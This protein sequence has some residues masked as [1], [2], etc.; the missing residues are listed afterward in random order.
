MSSGFLRYGN[1]YVNAV[2]KLSLI[3]LYITGDVW[4]CEIMLISYVYFM[5]RKHMQFIIFIEPLRDN[6]WLQ[7][8]KYNII[9]TQMPDITMS[10]Q[11]MLFVYHPGCVLCTKCYVVSSWST[12]YAV[13]SG[14]DW[15]FGIS[16]VIR[17]RQ[18]SEEIR[19]GFN[20][21]TGTASS[22]SSH[23]FSIALVYWRII[24]IVCHHFDLHD[25]MS[26]VSYVTTC[27]IDQAL[28][29]M[30]KSH[31]VTW[32]WITLSH[33]IALQWVSSSASWIGSSTARRGHRRV[34]NQRRW[35][36]WPWIQR[37]D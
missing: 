23:R 3:L 24:E 21:S 17:R 33:F 26:L 34:W 11:I 16:S 6:C 18:S 2:C 13:S 22:G 25:F 20:D 36:Y 7:Q 1:W 5:Q 9:A 8:L 37:Q 15:Y 29:E 12:L 31:S 27:Q 19:W 30:I 35:I 10:N 14:M 4:N 32:K 28:F